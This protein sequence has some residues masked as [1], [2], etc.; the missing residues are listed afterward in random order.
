MTGAGLKKCR[1]TTRSGWATGAASSVTDSDEVLVA[2]T[3]PAS[4]TSASAANSSCLSSSR[5]GAASI[6][7]AHGAS[8][9]TSLDR[10]DAADGRLGLGG[11]DPAP[12]HRPLQRRG[13]A[14]ARRGQRLGHR[15]VQQGARPGLG[16]Q[17]RDAQPHRAGA[18]HADGLR[19][20]HRGGA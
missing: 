18:D 16:R 14:L 19:N 7:T 11:R 17:L 6:T 1:P 15:V 2:S 4:T 10:L 13:H 9:A 8:P 5:S 20:R 12:G 3:Q